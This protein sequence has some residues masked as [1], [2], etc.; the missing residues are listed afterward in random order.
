MNPQWLTGK[1]RE[2]ETMKQGN[3]GSSEKSYFFRDLSNSISGN[4]QPF[5]C[6]GFFLLYPGMNNIQVKTKKLFPFWSRQSKCQEEIYQKFKPCKI[7]MSHINLI[8]QFLNL[9]LYLGCFSLAMK[10][11]LG[12]YFIFMQLPS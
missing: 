1:K 7:A 6:S 2:L 12:T 10:N 3:K 11:I 5:C 4:W 8:L 9:L